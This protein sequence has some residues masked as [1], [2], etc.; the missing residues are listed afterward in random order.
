MH[1]K[2]YFSQTCSRGRIAASPRPLG[3][4]TVLLVYTPESLIIAPRGIADPLFSTSLS[5]TV[6]GRERNEEFTYIF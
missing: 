2:Y 6:K 1:V 4:V 3:C 5:L